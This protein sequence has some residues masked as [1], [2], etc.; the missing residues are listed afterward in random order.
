MSLR[1][2]VRM[3]GMQQMDVMRFYIAQIIEKCM[4]IKDVED[5]QQ[6]LYDKPVTCF[7]CGIGWFSFLL[8][9]V[10]PVMWYYATVLYFGN[11]YH[12]DPRERT[13]LAAFAITVSAHLS[14]FLLS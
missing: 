3:L 8:G 5:Y 1:K 6:G 11:Y 10:F 9:F 4:L 14:V 2:I 7:C 12:K 13:S